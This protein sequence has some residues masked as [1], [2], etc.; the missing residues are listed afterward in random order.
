MMLINKKKDQFSDAY[1]SEIDKRLTEFDCIHAQS[2][3]QKVEIEKYQHIFKQRDQIWKS[4]KKK[5]IWDFEE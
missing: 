1:I 2:A 5:S 4:E 3:Q